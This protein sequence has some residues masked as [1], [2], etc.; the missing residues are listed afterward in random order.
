MKVHLFWNIEKLIYS[1]RYCKVCLYPKDNDLIQWENQMTQ[2]MKII[3]QIL[4]EDEHFL[5]LF[6]DQEARR[7]SNG[8]EKEIQRQAQEPTT[9]EIIMAGM[10]RRKQAI[11]IETRLE[12]LAFDLFLK[13]EKVIEKINN[14]MVAL[15][16]EKEEMQGNSDEATTSLTATV[17]GFKEKRKKSAYFHN[18]TIC[19]HFD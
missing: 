13:N 16:K 8:E 3:V 15:R 11:E 6:C 17:V 14:K 19:T 7:E 9:F 4:S 18:C 2:D 12:K 1:I 10:N 5:E